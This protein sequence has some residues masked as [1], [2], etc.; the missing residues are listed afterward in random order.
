L[1]RSPEKPTQ[2]AEVESPTRQPDN[3]VDPEEKTETSESVAE[4]IEEES[5]GNSAKKKKNLER[6][7]IGETETVEK[8]QAA[9]QPQGSENKEPKT[10]AQ[11]DVETVP[12]IDFPI[13][14]TGISESQ[15]VSTLGKPNSERRGWRPNSKVLVYYDVI[16][17]RVNLSYQ[18]DDTGKIRQTDI[19]LDSSVSLGAMQQ[20]LDKMLSGNA[21][22]DIKEKLRNVYNRQTNFSFFRTSNLEGKV[23]RDTKDRVTI[24]VWERGFQ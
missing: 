17:D 7:L 4:K 23:Q 11:I 21:S 18:S 19:A 6:I 12:E 13:V 2:L 15:L 22:A 20:T 24:S 3:F 10:L 1:L 16:P 8:P 14:T 9:N 5:K